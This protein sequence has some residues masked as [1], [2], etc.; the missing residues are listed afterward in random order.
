[1]RPF[2]ISTTRPCPFC[3]IHCGNSWCITMKMIQL[4]CP[5]CEEIVDVELEFFKKAISLCCMNCN[6]SFDAFP[7]QEKFKEHDEEFYD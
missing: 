6:K 2:Q 3:A 7:Y 4:E 1:M 5:H